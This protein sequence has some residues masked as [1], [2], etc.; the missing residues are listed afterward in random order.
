MI[1]LYN[2]LC[3]KFDHTKD[4]KLLE[5][6]D[7]V[8]KEIEHLNKQKTEGNRIRSR[9][10]VILEQQNSSFY[11]NQEKPNYKISHIT[12]LEGEKGDVISEP[13]EVLN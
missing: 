4:A 5:E 13:T 7:N 1:N 2:E 9:A 12:S 8:K 6:I 3:E 10:T 11:A